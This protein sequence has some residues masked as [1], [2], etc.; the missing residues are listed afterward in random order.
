MATY[1][2]TI[3]HE[4][5]RQEIAK[6]LPE[7]GW[8]LTGATGEVTFNTFNG[9]GEDVATPVIEQHILDAPK[10]GAN[11]IIL[12]Q[13]KDLEATATPRRIRESLT[14]ATWMKALDAQIA[15]LRGQL[16]W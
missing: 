15:A 6:V 11:S 1:Y 13:I 9:E 10:R 8:Y 3:D 2:G 16:Q 12:T 5:L 14:D 7:S 4:A